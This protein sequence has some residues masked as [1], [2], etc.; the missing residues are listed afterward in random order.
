MKPELTNTP[1]TTP[2]LSTHLQHLLLK[3]KVFKPLL[4][5]E[6]KLQERVNSRLRSMTYSPEAELLLLPLLP[7]RNASL[8]C[9]PRSPRLKSRSRG[10]TR[11]PSTLRTILRPLR[12][13]QKQLET[14]QW[15]LKDW[16]RQPKLPLS[17]LRLRLRPPK[18]QQ[19]LQELKPSLLQL[20]LKSLTGLLKKQSP[21][22]QLPKM[23]P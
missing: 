3:L 14:P 11:P 17:R 8:T 22:R 23:H 20:L 15:S 12:Q 9:S 2:I 19:T 18:L 7:I 13:L 6:R 1:H 16:L 21:T 10:I 4:M 5:P